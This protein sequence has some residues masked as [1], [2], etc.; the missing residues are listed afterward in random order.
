MATS[1]SFWRKR[2]RGSRIG[3][4]H[5]FHAFEKERKLIEPSIQKFKNLPE[6]RYR[7]NFSLDK[8]SAPW[9]ESNIIIQIGGAMASIN[10]K[11]LADSV[12]EEIKR[13]IQSGELK[14]G[15]RLPDQNTFAAQLGVSRTSLREAL[16]TLTRIGVIEQRPGY[17]TVFRSRIPVLFTDHLAPPLI[18]DKQASIELIEARRFIEIGAAE[19]AVKNASPEQIKEM[20][21]LIQ[22]MPR[23]LKEERTDDYIEQ[24]LAFHFSIAKA[25]HNRFIVNLFV[26]IR[27]F[28]EQYMRESFH[29]LPYM[30]ER[31]LKFH[32]SIFQAVK[33]GS[34]SKAVSQMERHILDV[35]RAIQLYYRDLEQKGRK[36]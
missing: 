34:R 16:S 32:Q 27:G 2:Y 20:E 7:R 33:D 5:F 18:S 24:D 9:Y 10:K 35:Q 6:N 1:S 17:G 19:L 29:L 28:M 4:F 11:K 31:S 13:M 21:L 23:S 14:E 30:L 26:N 36:K 3:S 22:E 25:S 15:H 8:K 12:I